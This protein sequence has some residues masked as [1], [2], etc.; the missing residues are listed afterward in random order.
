MS[1][2][3]YDYIVYGAGIAGTFFAVKK[4]S[5]SKSVLLLNNYGFPGENITECLY[6]FQK[7]TE[8]KISKNVKTFYDTVTSGVNLPFWQKDDS[9]LLNPESVKINLLKKLEVNQVELLFHV[10][11]QKIS[12][13]KDSSICISLLGKEGVISVHGRK[14]IDCS[15]EYSLTFLQRPHPEIKKRFVNIFITPPANEK[16]LKF[17]KIIKSVSLRDGRYW[18]SIGIDSKDDMFAENA[19]HEI[20]EDFSKLLDKSKSRIQLLP[21]RSEYTYSSEDLLSFEDTIYTID[22]ITGRTFNPDEQFIKASL[23]EENADKI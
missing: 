20:L 21:L 18:I 10:K 19:V 7:I 1:E 6:C 11:P 17:R 2:K 4:A 23:A 12:L 16:F 14:C 13:E 22:R 8:N 5:E 9:I 3:I 15:D